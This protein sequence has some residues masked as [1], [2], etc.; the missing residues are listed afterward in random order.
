MTERASGVQADVFDVAVVG[1]GVVGCAAFREFTLAGARCV[2][3]ERNADLIDGASKGNSGLLHTGFDAKPGSL[4]ARCVRDGYR[5]Y[6]EVRERLNLPLMATG[7]ILAAWTQEERERLPAI[8]AR[9]QANH[10]TD[11]R[12]I[13][14]EELRELEPGVSDAAVGGIL[15][16]GESIIDPWSAPFAYA[17][18]GVLNGGV[19]RRSTEVLGGRLVD[20]IWRLSTSK[21]SLG[22]RVVINCAG[23]FGDLVEAIAR[24][25]PFTI[26]PRKGQFVIFDKSAFGL[27]RGILL[28][29]PNERTKGV[30]VSRTAYGN[31]IVGPTAEDQEDRTK[32][33]VDRKQLMNLIAQGVRMVPALAGHQVTATYAGLRPA[34]LETKDYVIEALPGQRWITASGIRSTGLTAA[35]GIAKHL[36]GLYEENFETLAPLGDPVWPRVQNL[37]EG[38]PRRAFQAGRAEIVCH[39]EGVT[40]DDIEEALCEPLSARSLGGLKRRTRCMMGRCQGFYCSRRVLQIV[41]ER[42]PDFTL[43]ADSQDAAA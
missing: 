33:T 16:P 43:P 7:A 6:L 22:A 23:N 31:L 15:V 4:E 8:V 42:I 11:V 37:S 25:S 36:R 17:L 38:G 5:T 2:L 27:V 9:A 29:V 19:V 12:Q 24:P 32:A 18:Q 30:V 34:T 40:R 35:L 1:G 10:V 41:G 21:G 28:P 14:R 20:G 3:L 39:C 13:S 26:R